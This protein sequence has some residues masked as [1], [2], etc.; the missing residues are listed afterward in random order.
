MFIHFSC[1]TLVVPP[2][3]SPCSANI[4]LIRRFTGGGTVVVDKDTVF[5]TFVCNR[6][7]VPSQPQYPRDVMRWSEL[8]YKPVFDSLLRNPEHGF[9]LQD[10]DYCIGEQKVGGNAQSMT[11]NRWVHHT[12][13]LW[14][15][16]PARMDVLSLP[17]KQPA[18]REGR[19]HDS[20][21]TTLSSHV[22]DTPNGVED[23]FDAVEEQLRQGFA[24]EEAVWEHALAIA[25]TYDGRR[26]NKYEEL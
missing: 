7:D 25:N 1:A 11:R 14:D 19:D 5:V 10:H 15:Y 26:S 20:F 4:R 21:L 8:F 17:K 13:F 9:S 24:V 12:S 18:Y 2:C 22:Q 3:V 6:E 23:F 16:N